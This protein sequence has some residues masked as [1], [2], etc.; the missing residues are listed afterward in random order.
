[1]SDT[2]EVGRLLEERPDLEPAV[3]AALA[4][5]ETHGTWTFD[6]L[7]A[8]SG[9]FG[10][11]VSRGVVEKTDGEYRLADRQATRAALKGGPAAAGGATA[12]LSDVS[13]DLSLPTIES[14]VALALAGALAL[15]VA[16]R[17][18]T[19]NSIFRGGDV[20]LAGND[21]Y[22]YRY[23]VEQVAAAG[24]TLDFSGLSTLPPTVTGG[25]PLLVATLWFFTDLLGGGQAASGIVTVWYPIVAAILVG[26]LTYLF[27]RELTDDRRVAVAAVAILA[28]LPV[29]AQR[30]GLGFADHH[31]FDYI[32]LTLTAAG[33]VVLARLPPVRETLF[34]P[35]RRSLLGALA[36]GFGVAGQVLAWEAGPLLLLPLLL[37]FPVTTLLAARDEESS[38]WA[39]ALTLAALGLAAALAALVHLAFGWH[40]TV[41]AFTPALLFVG[42]AG[43]TLAAEAVRRADLPVDDLP[44]VLGLQVLGLIGSLTLITVVVPPFGETLFQRIDVLVDARPIVEYQPLFSLRSNGWLVL[45]GPPLFVAIAGFAWASVRAWFGGREWL[46][47]AL[48]GWSFLF[49]A[50][51]QQRF[52]GEL[53]PFVAVFAGFGVVYLAWKVDVA[54]PP[55]PL[56]DDPPSGPSIGKPSLGQVGAVLVLFALVG[57]YGAFQ[58][59]IHS[60]KAPIWEGEYETAAFIDEYAAEH[61]MEYPDDYVF[62]KWWRNR[63]YNYFVNGEASSYGYAQAN[64]TPFLQSSNTGEWYEEFEERGVGFV[65]LDPT[66]SANSDSTLRRLREHRGSRYA[67]GPG[68]SNFRLASEA[69]HQRGTYQV[70]ELVPGATVTGTLATN[71]SLVTATDVTVDG[72]SFQYARAVRVSENG[73]FSVTLS[74][75]GEYAIGNQTVAVSDEAVEAGETIR[76][77]EREREEPYQVSP[78]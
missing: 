26:L 61:G 33:L 50:A 3:A 32:W 67:G 34:D 44:A 29:H 78:S 27:T 75:A 11:L 62:S 36:V 38:L 54:R 13:L 41:V 31:A 52:A 65:V 69:Q 14:R 9:A 46:V 53:S 2:P 42:G 59:P 37:Y 60:A 66:Y 45:F 70:F 24:G 35:D 7:D 55:A 17:L 1:M 18:T 20:V 56:A 4:T 12:R 51:L 6:D 16:F 47:V 21:P 25:E 63:M 43:V 74:Y 49:L 48:Y 76:V 72:T 71:E 5:D 8:D 30:S 23:W 64:Y 77:N 68:V 40:S 39:N 10:E 58:S 15:V 57:G 19:W 22:F 73:S 28:V